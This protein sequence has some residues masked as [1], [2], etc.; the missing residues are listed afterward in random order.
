MTIPPLC[1]ARLARLAVQR[2]GLGED[3]GPGAVEVHVAKARAQAS[4]RWGPFSPSD[5]G[6]AA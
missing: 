2:H 5:L 3:S 1:T 6:A 4:P